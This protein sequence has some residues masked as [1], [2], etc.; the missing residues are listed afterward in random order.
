MRYSYRIDTGKFAVS[1]FTCV[2]LLLLSLRAFTGAYAVSGVFLLI[3]AVIFGYIA[4]LYGSTLTL[5]ETSIRRSFFGI[6]MK[7][8]PWNKVAEVGVIGIKV[9]NR[10]HPQRTG[11]LYI[12]FAPQY[13]D[14]DARFRLALEWPPKKGLYLSYQPER[15]Q[16]IQSIWYGKIE[17]YNVGDLH[18]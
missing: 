9:F 18:F 1:L 11:K 10:N 15:I 12:Y 2:V 17:T 4:V 7:E 16:A 3:F 14:D 13:L 6:H 5:D 8:M